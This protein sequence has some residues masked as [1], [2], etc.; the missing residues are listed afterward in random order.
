[1]AGRGDDAWR[2]CRRSAGPLHVDSVGGDHQIRLRRNRRALLLVVF[3][4]PLPP[5]LRHGSVDLATGDA[6]AAAKG[7]PNRLVGR[8][9]QKSWPSCGNSQCDRTSINPVVSS[10]ASH[11][12][13]C[14]LG[15]W[16]ALHVASAATSVAGQSRHSDRRPITSGLPRKA[17]DP[18]TGQHF[19]FVPI[20]EINRSPRRR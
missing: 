6:R 11:S 17:D 19:A 1:M 10:T 5:L 18:R 20:G 14:P 2:L 4:R 13:C 12:S 7:S 9:G 3:L 16:T 15:E 8:S